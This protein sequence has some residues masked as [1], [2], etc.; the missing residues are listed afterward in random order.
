MG[1]LMARIEQKG[2]LF[3]SRLYGGYTEK[4]DYDYLVYVPD[5]DTFIKFLNNNGVKTKDI[6]IKSGYENAQ[7]GNDS[8]IMFMLEDKEI[9]IILYTKLDKWQSAK[10]AYKKL[11]E[12]MGNETS[13]LIMADSHLR[14]R[15]VELVFDSELN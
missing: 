2:L 15:I 5:E 10:N 14:H 3:G 7:L 12:F 13:K 4:S 6:V 11:K 1:S 9:N 8:S